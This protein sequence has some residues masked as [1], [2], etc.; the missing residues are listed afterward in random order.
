MRRLFRVIAV[1]L[2]T[3]TAISATYAAYC[4]ILIWSGNFHTIRPNE[5]Y[6]SSQ[7]TGAEF[8]AE[9]E[10]HHIRSILNLRGPNPGDGW[11]RDELAA[12]QA[13]GV[14]HYDVGISAEQAVPP[15]KI[16]KILAVLRDAPKPILIHCMSGADRAGFAS[17]LYR[18]AITGE[19]P[20]EA[21]EELSLL[22]GHFPYLTSKTDA[23]DKSFDSWAA[24]HK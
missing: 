2:G 16:E 15:E 19:N 23:M 10:R 7:L 24:S 20:E 4:G 6:R 18:Y 21:K 13:G 3:L 11:Y 17:A 22:Y 1:T 5:A 8:A 9:I 14:A 12:S